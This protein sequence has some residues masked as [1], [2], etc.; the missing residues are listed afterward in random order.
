MIPLMVER[1]YRVK[2]WLGL[3][4]GSRLWYAFWPCKELDDEVEFESRV[5]Q[6]VKEIGDRGKPKAAPLPEAVPPRKAPSPA[7]APAPT[8]APAPALVQAPLLR[9][10]A[11]VQALAPAPGPS[12]AP[13]PAPRPTVA[14]SYS[15]S[16][17]Q[18]PMSHS[19]QLSAESTSG[20][21]LMEVSAFMDRQLDKQRAHDE[22]LRQEAKAWKAELRQEMQQ[23]IDQQKQQMEKMLEELKPTPPPEAI[24]EQRLA[25]LQVRIEALHAN[26]LLSDDELYAL[27]DMVADFV[28]F[29]ASLVGVVVLDG[30][31]R[32]ENATKLLTLISL[33]ERITADSA[34]ARQARRKYV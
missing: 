17:Q 29:E 23:Q 4:L 6:V 26:K 2:G 32:N 18:S 11:P 31:R 7:S 27:E 16:L 5:D 10:P 30:M 25:A 9:A 20:A 19:M 1:D 33:S 13:A 12:P 24:S 3:I 8:P 14:Q 22:K 28:E 21:S 15:P 34:F